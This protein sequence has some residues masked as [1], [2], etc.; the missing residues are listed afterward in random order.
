MTEKSTHVTPVVFGAG[1]CLQNNWDLILKKFKPQYLADNSRDK[2]NTYPMGD[3]V[4]C[5]SPEAINELVNPRVLVAVGD[6]YS[7]EAIRGQLADMGLDCEIVVEQL[8]KWSIEEEL[9]EHLRVLQKAVDKR[10]LLFN[11]PEHDNVGDHLISI[12]E[13]DFVKKYFPEYECIEITDMEFVRFRSRIRSFVQKDDLILVTGGGFLGSMWLYNGELNV[14]GII[15]DYPDN[16]IVIMPQT[17]YFEKNERG[18]AE[19]IKTKAVYTKHKNLTICLRD[20]QAYELA[21]ELFGESAMIK[22][23]PDMALSL[24]YSKEQEARKGAVLCFRKDKESILGTKQK[25]EITDVL[26]NLGM[27]YEFTLMHTGNVFSLATRE[28]EIAAKA[29]QMKAAEIVITDTLHCMVLCA[30]TGTPC[31]AFDNLSS[32]ISGVYAWIEKT[33]YIHLYKPGE[34]VDNIIRDLLKGGYGQYNAD[35]LANYYAELAG[36]MRRNDQGWKKHCD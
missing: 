8:E 6:P 33:P 27:S 12:A 36:M 31:L 29:K 2:W 3:G 21:Q 32:K 24:D 10:I 9:P 30:I 16:Q 34:N 5:I 14:R 28:S 18:R 20:K 7:I 23:F 35:F 25:Q 15:E 4:K 26:E 19:C 17:I 22:Y 1:I 11:S 13:L